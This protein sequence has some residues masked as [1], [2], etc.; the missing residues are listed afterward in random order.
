MLVR[1]L[2][3]FVVLTV[4]IG[5]NRAGSQ[6]GENVKAQVEEINILL[7]GRP[8]EINSMEFNNEAWSSEYS[9]EVYSFDINRSGML[10]V[11]IG[12]GQVQ[13]DEKLGTKNIIF[14]G[15]DIKDSIFLNRKVVDSIFLI[16]N[17]I[18][19]NTGNLTSSCPDDVW[20]AK[21][22]SVTKIRSY[23]V[24]EELEHKN[25]FYLYD[26]YCLIKFMVRYSPI[27]IVD[28]NEA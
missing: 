7:S 21:F 4:I 10:R 1:F 3:F 19:Y 20:F 26:L 16:I 25:A 14:H 24:G 15:V 18:Q 17:R 2:S 13:C 6:S 9:D 22:K 27:K 23:Y 11:S 8:Y 12:Y 5:C 28:F